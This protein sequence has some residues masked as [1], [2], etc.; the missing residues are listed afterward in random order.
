MLVLS[1]KSGEEICIGS[2]IKIAVLGIKGGR[3]SLGLSAPREVSIQRAELRP[4]TGG[5][6]AKRPMDDSAGDAERPRTVD[7]GLVR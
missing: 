6:S 5:A 2:G 1:R 7:P 4:L 3:V